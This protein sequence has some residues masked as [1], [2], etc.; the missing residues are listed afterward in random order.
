MKVSKLPEMVVEALNDAFDSDPESINK[1]FTFRAFDTTGETPS[2]RE[3]VCE[4]FSVK[5]PIKEGQNAWTVL[6][7]VNTIVERIAPGSKVAIIH[8][9]K[10]M[11]GFSIGR[12]KDSSVPKE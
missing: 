1:L 6:D 7:I 5:F 4:D 9:S 2:A 12:S 8:G 3:Q 11:E 10:G